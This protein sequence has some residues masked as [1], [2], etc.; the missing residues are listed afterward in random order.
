MSTGHEWIGLSFHTQI[1]AELSC[2]MPQG[3]NL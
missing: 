1:R 2:L 3:L